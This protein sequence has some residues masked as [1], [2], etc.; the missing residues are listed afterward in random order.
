[1]KTLKYV[2][3]SDMLIR[4][5]GSSWVN[6]EEVVE[7]LRKA[8]IEWLKEIERLTNNPT[9]KDKDMVKLKCGENSVETTLDRW[10]TAR[11]YLDM[12]IEHFFNLNEEE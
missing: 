1:M 3:L 11:A 7:Q 5:D 2:P 9:G 8:A 10:D 6:R 12:W 4:E